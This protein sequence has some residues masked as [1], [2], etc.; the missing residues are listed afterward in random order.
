MCSVVFDW[1]LILSFVLLFSLTLCA[2]LPQGI[3]VHS[4]RKWQPTPV[5]LLGKSHG[6]RSLVGYNP[7]GRKESDTTERLRLSPYKQWG[8]LGGSVVKNISANA[9]DIG[10]IPGWGR[11]PGE[12][13]GNHGIFAWEILWTEESGGLQL[14]G[15]WKVR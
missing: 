7:W 5:L 12:G 6:Q 9:G 8:F 15:S 1:S 4:Y 14:M 11:W 10:S 2:V 3:I 13:N